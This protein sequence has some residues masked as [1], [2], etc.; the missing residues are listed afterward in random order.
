MVSHQISAYNLENRIYY[1]NALISQKRKHHI[2]SGGWFF[3]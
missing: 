3:S 2:I 1:K